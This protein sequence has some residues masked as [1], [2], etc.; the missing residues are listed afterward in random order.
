MQPGPFAKSEQGTK[1]KKRAALVELTGI[2]SR[3]RV[4][5]VPT[6]VITGS[7]HSLK[8]GSNRLD[9][10]PIDSEIGISGARC[11]LHMNSIRCFVDEE[12]QVF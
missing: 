6:T 1:D 3:Q 7:L 10:R 8:S 2:G 9:S 12:F 11:R 5:H 4:S